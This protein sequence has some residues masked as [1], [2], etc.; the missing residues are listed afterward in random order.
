MTFAD[1]VSELAVES[2]TVC[3][4]VLEEPASLVSLIMLEDVVYPEGEM[5]GLSDV[6]PDAIPPL[7]VFRRF[8]GQ[9]PRS[10][11]SLSGSVLRSTVVLCRTSWS[12]VRMWS[13]RPP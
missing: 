10:V 8:L 11:S 2:P 9:L 13:R 7:W 4:P 12:A 1:D 3:S 6:V 5:Y